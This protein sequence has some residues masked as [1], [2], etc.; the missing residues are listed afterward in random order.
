VDENDTTDYSV[1]TK[2]EEVLEM[3]D[4]MSKPRSSSSIGSHSTSSS[5]SSL[6]LNWT[7]KPVLPP[8]AIEHI[9]ASNEEDSDLAY[10]DPELDESLPFTP[11]SQGVKR[12]F[13]VFDDLDLNL[14]PTFDDPNDRRKSQIIMRAKLDEI[15]RVIHSR[16]CSFT[17]IYHNSNRQWHSYPHEPYTPIY[18]FH[19]HRLHCHPQTEGARLEFLPSLPRL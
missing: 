1:L 7:R 11:Q 19:F 16:D 3:L 14:D 8:L 12:E 2:E 6:H 9:D 13:A 5:T 18:R 10:T 4:I 17:Q 15:E